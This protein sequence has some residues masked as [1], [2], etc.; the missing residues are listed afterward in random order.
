[1]LYKSGIAKSFTLIYRKK[2]IYHGENAN[3]IMARKFNI[4]LYIADR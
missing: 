1:M 4:I 2:F 3:V